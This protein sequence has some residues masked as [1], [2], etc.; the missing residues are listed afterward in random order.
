[1]RMSGGRI[2]EPAYRYLQIVLEGIP[3]ANISLA[4]TCRFRC[5]RFVFDLLLELVT[6]SLAEQVAHSALVDFFLYTCRYGLL[7][8][9][10]VLT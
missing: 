6:T 4:F 9:R 10:N 1:M 7:G 2:G 5:S 8:G 3:S